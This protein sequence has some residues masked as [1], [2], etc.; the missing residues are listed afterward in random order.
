MVYLEKINKFYLIIAGILL[1]TNF[2]MNSY[3]DTLVHHYDISI[4]GEL[5]HDSFWYPDWTR[6]YENLETLERKGFWIFTYPAWLFDGWHLI[7]LFR[8]IVLAHVL[9]F[10]Y[11]SR[12]DHPRNWKIYLIY[13]IVFMGLWT[14]T[15]EFFYHYLLL[16]K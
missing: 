13:F 6:K 5:G 1:F 12:N 4:Y 10:L 16:T 7:K 9:W 3:E 14:L 15:H 2:A 11:I 8:Y